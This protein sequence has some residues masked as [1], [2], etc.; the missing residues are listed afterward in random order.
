MFWSADKMIAHRQRKPTPVRQLRPDVSPGLALVIDKMMA[1]NP[2]DRFDCANDV[3]EALEPW[4]PAE[5]PPLVAE[6]L[7]SR[8]SS[9]ISIVP[10]PVPRP[11]NWSLGWS[12]VALMVM[13]GC[14]LGVLA[15]R[16]VQ[17]PT[18]VARSTGGR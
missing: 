10:V 16:L 2:N 8:E 11:R 18:A 9:I 5:K 17:A 13:L 3:A 6:P 7:I 1:K 12:G 4:L 15:G 14:G